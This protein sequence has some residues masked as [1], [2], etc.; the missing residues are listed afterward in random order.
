MFMENG[1]FFIQVLC[2]ISEVD[3]SCLCSSVFT[4]NAKEDVFFFS[5]E[6]FS[7]VLIPQIYSAVQHSHSIAETPLYWDCIMC[8]YFIYISFLYYFK[9][10]TTKDSQG[11]DKRCTCGSRCFPL[12]LF[13][14]PFFLASPLSS[15]L[16]SGTPSKEILTTFEIVPIGYLFVWW[17]GN[18]GP[19]IVLFATCFSVQ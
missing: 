1:S 10:S 14:R 9:F 7:R 3:S 15:Q 16:A 19:K 4:V 8:K 2:V 6:Q 11:E 13:I 12:Q 17:K 5:Y 18:F